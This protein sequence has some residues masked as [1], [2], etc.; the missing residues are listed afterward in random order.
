MHVDASS[1]LPGINSEIANSFW[2]PNETKNYHSSVAESIVPTF[3]YFGLQGKFL[4][5]KYNFHLNDG[6]LAMGG[7]TIEKIFRIPG[8]NQT[9][10][11]CNAGWMLQPFS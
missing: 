1:L 10:D 6:C 9:H 5:E 8:R 11:L 7:Q 3:F 2:V 4:G